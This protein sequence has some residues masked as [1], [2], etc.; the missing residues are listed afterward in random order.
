MAVERGKPWPTNPWDMGEY[1]SRLVF[2]RAVGPDGVP[3]MMVEM[4]A[5]P[6]TLRAIIT[7]EQAADWIAKFQSELAD[8]RRTPIVR[9]SGLLLPNG[10][11]PPPPGA[12]T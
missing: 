5:G 11:Q 6:G 2:G 8:L 12:A 4:Q 7:Q 10:Q 1:Q 3:R 9:R